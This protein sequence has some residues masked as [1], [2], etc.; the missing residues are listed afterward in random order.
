MSE[1]VNSH[2]KLLLF[3]C[4]QFIQRLSAVNCYDVDSVR[5][6]KSIR[7]RYETTQSSNSMSMPMPIHALRTTH[8]TNFS[9]YVDRFVHNL[10]QFDEHHTNT[11][12]SRSA[13]LHRCRNSYCSLFMAFH[14]HTMLCDLR[15]TIKLF[16]SDGIE[17]GKPLMHVCGVSITRLALVNCVMTPTD[18]DRN[19]IWNR[20][21]FPCSRIVR[22]KAWMQI[23]FQ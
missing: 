15:N 10:Q 6:I 9:L 12:T 8:T 1:I 3:S 5:N 11:R 20:K 23:L 21:N 14:S 13:R 22:R 19:R 16:Y 4:Q 7:N 17:C 18:T 2:W